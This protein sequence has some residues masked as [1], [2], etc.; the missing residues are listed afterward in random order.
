MQRLFYDELVARADDFDR[1]VSQTPDVDLFC[2]S[3]PW[4]FSAYEAFAS[5]YDTW[6][7]HSEH[8][9]VAL[10]QSYHDK[11]GRFRQPMEASWCLACPFVGVDPRALARDFAAESLESASEW[12]LLFLS[13]I[14]R[15]TS[16]YKTLIESFSGQYFVGVGPPVSRYVASLDGGLDGFMSRRTSKFRANLRRIERRAG[17]QGVR[18]EYITDFS[19]RDWVTVYDTILEIET[20][21][22]KGMADTGISDRPMQEFYRCMLPRLVDN[23]QLRVLLLYLGEQPVAFVFG[24]VFGGTYRG[25]QLSYDH[26]HR[27]LSLGNLAQLAIIRELGAEGIANYDLGS[28]LEYKSTWAEERFDTISLVIR[29]W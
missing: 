5:E 12:D 14:C 9:Y 3:T 2:S 18:A 22:W 24:A 11:L 21:S 28:E 25:L 23:G 26:A 20:R 15:D 1:A 16:L 17:E 19:K 10:V 29:R 6:I 13:G 27:K 7:A 8:G 4:I